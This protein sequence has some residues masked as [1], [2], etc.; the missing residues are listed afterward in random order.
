M[1]GRLNKIEFHLNAIHFCIYKAHYKSYKM[2]SKIS[3]SNLIHE[4][5]FQK[6]RYKKLGI[7]IHKEIDK[8]FGD[9]NFGMSMMVAGGVLIALFFFLFLS[10]INILLRLFV[11]HKIYLQYPHFAIALIISLALTYFFVFKNDCY[12]QYFDKFE[13]WNHGEKLKYRWLTFGF[14]ILVIIF[15]ILMLEY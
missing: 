14:I 7:D 11:G 15:F 13:K 2:Y 4:L 8:A 1:I 5:P 6:R 9:K 10:A 3:P 12:L